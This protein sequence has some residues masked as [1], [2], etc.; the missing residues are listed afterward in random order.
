[1]TGVLR[2]SWPDDEKGG[3]SW[4]LVAMTKIKFHLYTYIYIYIYGSDGLGMIGMVI[5]KLN[6]MLFGGWDSGNYPQTKIC[7][8]QQTH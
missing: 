4:P 8:F 2:V 6:W 1:M 7:R 3:D 5:R